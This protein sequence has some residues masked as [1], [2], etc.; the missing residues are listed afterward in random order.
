[1]ESQEDPRLRRI[2]AQK[3]CV[4]AEIAFPMAALLFLFDPRQFFYVSNCNSP[5]W[6]K[7]DANLRRVGPAIPIEYLSLRVQQRSLR[8]PAVLP[9]YASECPGA[10]EKS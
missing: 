10:R 1:M 2:F 4:V 9:T 7:Q 5:H 8:P 3:I 6:H